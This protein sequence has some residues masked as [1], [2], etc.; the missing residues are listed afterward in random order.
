MGRSGSRGGMGDL[1]AADPLGTDNEIVEVA[2]LSHGRSAIPVV[3]E[4][5]G[6]DPVILIAA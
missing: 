5:N 3:L 1:S 6:V 2:L 4:V